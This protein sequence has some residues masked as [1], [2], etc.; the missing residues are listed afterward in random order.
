MQA[1]WCLTMFSN[2]LMGTLIRFGDTKQTY[3]QLKIGSWLPQGQITRKVSVKQYELHKA[4][5]VHRDKWLIL[6]FL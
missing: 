3:R 2:L 5:L 6:I 4:N 1:N